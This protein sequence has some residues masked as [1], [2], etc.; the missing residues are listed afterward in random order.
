MG[1]APPRQKRRPLGRPNLRHRA[2][3][4]LHLR[5]KIRQLLPTMYRWKNRER[6][7]PR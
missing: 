6:R 1:T 5:S 3:K 7:Q 2:R 4:I